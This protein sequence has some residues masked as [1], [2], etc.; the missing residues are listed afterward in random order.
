MRD[1]VD[2]ASGPGV[3]LNRSISENHP[4]RSRLNGGRGGGV[5]ERASSRE[6]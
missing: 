3:T 2:L 5:W 6:I 1:V 4:I